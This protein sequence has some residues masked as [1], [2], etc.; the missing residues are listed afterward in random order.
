MKRLI[1]IGIVLVFLSSVVTAQDIILSPTPQPQI[2]VLN[3]SVVDAFYTVN[4]D[5]PALGE[6]ITITLVI[7]MP[8]DAELIEWPELAGDE[9]LEIIENAPQM[10][11]LSAKNQAQRGPWKCSHLDDVVSPRFRLRLWH[12]IHQKCSPRNFL[13][14]YII[15]MNRRKV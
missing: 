13:F 3:S 9:K 5:T 7:D 6:R 2:D 11:I 4:N 15:F 1:F 10:A 12:V 8:I 14:K